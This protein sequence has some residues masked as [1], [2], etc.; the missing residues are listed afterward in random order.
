MS[1]VINILMFLKSDVKEIGG[2]GSAV[3][4]TFSVSTF[5]K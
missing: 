3:I 2:I 1:T 4:D 5:R